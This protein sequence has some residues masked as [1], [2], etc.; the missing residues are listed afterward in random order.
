LVNDK[1]N[2]RRSYIREI[3]AVLHSIESKGW[4][5]AAEIY[6]TKN[7]YRYKRSIRNYYCTKEG[8]LLPDEL[9]ETIN[10]SSY[11][12]YFMKSLI[13]KVEHIGYVKGK[14]D[15]IYKRIREKLYSLI[16]NTNSFY[17]EPQILFD[18]RFAYITNATAK[19]VV[20]YAYAFLK[21]SGY[22]DSEIIS[23]RKEYSKNNNIDIGLI[24][25]NFEKQSI[26]FLNL[27][28]YMLKNNRFTNF[29]NN[30]NQTSF[31]RI[32]K[33]IKDPASLLKQFNRI[34][35]HPSFNCEN[36]RNDYIEED[37]FFANTGIFSEEIIVKERK[38]YIISVKFLIALGMRE[39][40][41]CD[42]HKIH[43]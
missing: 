20:Y 34:I 21:N 13:G 8:L 31:K 10:Y 17:K 12:W 1:L 19:S 6:I 38:G 23:I 33:F 43:F 11:G 24:T 9:L 41:V 32:F 22:T 16:G 2:V 30:L 26:Q 29:V 4:K 36:I 37:R 42:Y 40:K 25:N 15:P 14:E 3:R 7:K 39:C 28:S 5:D 35:F 27:Y 18:E